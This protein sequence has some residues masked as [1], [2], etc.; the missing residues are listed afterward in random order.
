VNAGDGRNQHPTQAL[1]D[2][3]TIAEAFARDIAVEA[4][5]RGLVVAICGDIDNGRVPHSDARLFA[6]L[7]A[8]VRL[9]GPPELLS[10]ATAETLGAPAIRRFEDALAGAHVVAMLRVQR[11]RLPAGNALADAAAYHAAWGLTAARFALADPSAVVLHPGPVNRGVE[12][13]DEVADGSRSRILRQV[14]LGVAVRMAVLARACG[15]L[16]HGAP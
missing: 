2:A 6:R 9:A 12:L 8:E 3:L 14:S 10:D 4:P 1:L 15:R 7:G 16:P 13:V 11:E 5:L